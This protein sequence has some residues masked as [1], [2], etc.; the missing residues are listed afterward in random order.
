[1]Q[2]N[3]HAV[4]ITVS[5]AGYFTVKPTECHK[6]HGRVIKDTVVNTQALEYITLGEMV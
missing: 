2:R 3:I 1:M 5:V 4:R 6:C